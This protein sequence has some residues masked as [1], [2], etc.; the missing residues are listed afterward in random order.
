M[1]YYRLSVLK[2]I[3]NENQY[4]T[5]VNYLSSLSTN[6]KITISQIKNSSNAVI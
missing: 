6:S 2:Q 3:L 5:F 4:N 1:L